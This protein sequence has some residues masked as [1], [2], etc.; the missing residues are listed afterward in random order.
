MAASRQPSPKSEPTSQQ[1]TP[2][3]EPTTTGSN[4]DILLDI[5]FQIVATRNEIQQR[6]ALQTLLDAYAAS[7]PSVDRAFANAKGI[8]CDSK[9][10]KLNN[11]YDDVSK[12]LGLYWPLRDALQ[13]TT[14]EILPLIL[15]NFFIASTV[16]RCQILQNTELQ[17]KAKQSFEM[18]A[19]YSG[20]NA[21]KLLDLRK[22]FAQL[23]GKR[24][25]LLTQQTTKQTVSAYLPLI[26][27]IIAGA[28]ILIMAV[29]RIYE[30]DLQMEWVASGQVI[31]FTTVLILLTCPH[32][33]GI[34]GHTR[35]TGVGNITW[36]DSRVR[37]RARRR[38][39]YC[40]GSAKRHNGRDWFD[41]SAAAA[42]ASFAATS[43]AATSFA[44]TS[45]VA[46][47]FV[48]TSFV[49]TSFVA[50]SFVATASDER[51]SINQGFREIL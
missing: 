29:V 45:F 3:L 1:P 24:S 19:N 35:R 28:A 12:A 48:A 31:Q 41:R 17:E 30:P 22:S 42:T 4:S 6:A 2:E 27:G 18:V 25:E 13:K 14:G 11:N 36:R 5:E 21:A 32:G 51:R 16:A 34:N 10:T 49:A 44:A 38:S 26:I 8:N 23:L 15:S 46:T 47:S 9:S 20:D 50:T 37:A 33:T 7:Q 40:A 39:R 43:F